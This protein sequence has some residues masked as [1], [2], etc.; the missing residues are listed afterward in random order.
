MKK[1]LLMMLCAGLLV[2][3]AC[4]NSEKVITGDT[5]AGVN[6]GTESGNKDAE[7]NT[8]VSGGATEAKGY[9]FK[10]QDLSV[11]IDT[12]ASTYLDVLGEPVS[13]YEAPSCAFE[14]LDKFYTYS[15]YEIDTY[16]V[17]D[18]DYVLAVALLDDTVS[19]AEGVCIGDA[20]SKVKDVYGAP[21]TESATS[22]VYVKDGMKLTFIFKDDAIVS[23]EYKT[24]LLDE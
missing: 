15:G 1:G 22:A 7:G 14:A 13:Y 19:T 10:V 20:A 11:A 4:G 17:S 18:V 9:V 5:E 21:T 3:A 24:M 12:Q 8:E 6:V 2:F 23:I 16:S